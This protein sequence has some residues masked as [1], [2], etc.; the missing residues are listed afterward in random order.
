MIQHLTFDELDRLIT[1]IRS[2]LWEEDGV[3][4]ADKLWDNDMLGQ[5]ADA[6]RF[7]KLGPTYHI[8]HPVS[9]GVAPAPVTPLPVSE[10]S[11]VDPMTYKVVAKRGRK[12]KPRNQLQSALETIIK[13]LPK[14]GLQHPT[15][16]QVVLLEHS[17]I[18]SHGAATNVWS[19]EVGSGLDFPVVVYQ[20]DL[21]DAL[22]RAGP[23]PM[24]KLS[25]GTGS[26]TSLCV[27][28]EAAT[29]VGIHEALLEDW[30]REFVFPPS[31]ARGTLT[32][33]TVKTIVDIAAFSSTDT[34]RDTLNCVYL[35]RDVA[36]ATDGYRLELRVADVPENL[37]KIKINNMA[38]KAIASFTNP[39][40]RHVDEHLQLSEGIA[41]LKIRTPS[42]PFP[43]YRHVLPKSSEVDVRTTVAFD[44]K[45]LYNFVS[46]CS[47]DVSG[48]VV[49]SIARS[50]EPNMWVHEGAYFKE[51]TR[52]G[53]VSDTRM[54]C[55]LDR[56][57]P[58]R[59]KNGERLDYEDI[60]IGFSP[61]YLTQ[62]LESSELTYVYINI[63]DSFAPIIISNEGYIS[64]LDLAPE[65]DL[66][67]PITS[68]CNV[69]MPKRV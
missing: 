46:K 39:D 36:V 65:G 29:L 35:D 44:R 17:R 10:A 47:K 3:M 23:E 26:T 22:K 69:L 24:F 45:Q 25:Q 18:S 68:N 43:D 32:A 9:D 11:V 6:L 62:A 13:S 48:T 20:K 28:G 33:P 60:S 31:A 19:F 40:Y 37:R 51:T 53:D 66:E 50:V 49:L 5:I 1:R 7:T 14:R 56:P 41:T 15:F 8:P 4:N 30:P 67:R 12:P 64:I 63:L 52:D 34:T 38:I 61:V 54:S 58:R 42:S 16:D 57:A 55:L 21:L 59:D 2:I 27:Y